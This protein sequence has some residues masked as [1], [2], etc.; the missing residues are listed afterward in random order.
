MPGAAVTKDRAKE[1]FFQGSSVL[2]KY[3][4]QGIVTKV[5]RLKSE[6][7]PPRRRT[8]PD[9]RP[10][11]GVREADRRRDDRPG[12][13]PNVRA[14]RT[15]SGDSKRRMPTT[16]KRVGSKRRDTRGGNQHRGDR[17]GT[18]RPGRRRCETFYEIHRPPKVGSACL[19]NFTHDA[20]QTLPNGYTAVLADIEK[21]FP[22]G[23]QGDTSG[24][25]V[26]VIG[27]MII[28]LDNNWQAVWYWDCFDPAH[29]GNGYPSLT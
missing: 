27:V 2:S 7:A 16:K 24:L 10:S 4:N 28:V 23:T 1:T 14:A 25:P 13:A 17:T 8:P 12:L 18:P 20:I 5:R 9:G 19:S 11:Q 21:I 26:D 29:G 22:A 3:W 15:Q 6:P